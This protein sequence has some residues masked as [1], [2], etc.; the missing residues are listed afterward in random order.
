MSYGAIYKITNKQ[1]GKCY[2]GASTQIHRR[3]YTHKHG[4]YPPKEFNYKMK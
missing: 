4:K 3:F 2:I 1:D